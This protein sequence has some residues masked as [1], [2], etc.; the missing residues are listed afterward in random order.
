MTTDTTLETTMSNVTASSSSSSSTYR[1]VGAYELLDTLGSGNFGKV[2][3]ARHVDTRIHY[4]IKIVDTNVLKQNLPGNLDIRREMSIL[5]ALQHPN[6]VFL[7]EVMVSPY[8][9]YLVMDL[10]EGGDFFHYLRTHGKLNEILARKFFKQLVDAVCYCHS[11]G[12]FHRDLKPENLLLTSESIA[13]ANLKITDFGFSAMKDHGGTLLKT[14]CGSPHYCAPEVWNGTCS[15]TGYD[16]SKADAFSIGVILFVLLTGGQPFYDVDEDKLLYKVDR[17]HV[18]YPSFLG[19]EAVDLLSKLLVRD[20]QKRWS[21]HMVRRHSWYL[22]ASLDDIVNIDVADVAST[23]EE[24]EEGDTDTSV[25]M[26]SA[27]SDVSSHKSYHSDIY[28]YPF[29]HTPFQAGERPNAKGPHHSHANIL[30]QQ[31]H[32]HHNCCHSKEH[33]DCARSQYEVYDADVA[34]NDQGD[35]LMPQ[36]DSSDPNTSSNERQSMSMSCTD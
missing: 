5:R 30:P 11:H 10:A 12:V 34:E 14:N 35:T 26:T 23:D 31:N 19:D 22:A 21:L 3:R 18:T 32:Q 28:P 17:C 6:I 9:V 29:Q 15:K 16:G 36:R 27:S 1:R 20:P 25:T 7:H 4:A 13:N 2:K 33:G 8:R 24:E